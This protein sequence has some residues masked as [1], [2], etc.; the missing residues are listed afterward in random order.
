M[1]FVALGGSAVWS[2]ASGPR[3]TGDER[4][5]LQGLSIDRLP[6]LPPDPSNRVADNSRAVKLGQALFFDSRLSA[7]G[8]VSCASCHQPVR[9]FSDALPLGRGVGQTGRRTM[10]VVGV[11]YAPFLFWD[12]RKDSLWAQALGPLESAV[13]HGGDR[14]MYARLIARYHRARYEAL[15]GPLPDLTGLPQHA[16]PV[17]NLQARASWNGL[18]RSRQR[19]VTEVYVNI[20]KALAAYERRL[21][22]A[23]S[24]FDRYV[25]AVLANDTR[26]MRTTFT[27]AEADGLRLFIGRAS[28]VSCHSGPLLTDGDFHNTGIP[29]APGLPPDRGRASGAPLVRRDEFNCLSKYSDAPPSECV[30]LRFLKTDGPELEGQFKVPPLRGVARTAPYMHAGQKATLRD[31]LEHYNLA[32]SAAVGHSELMPLHLSGQ[33]L[34]HIEAFMRT[35]DSPVDAPAALLRDPFART[36]ATPTPQ[37]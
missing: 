31:V 17:Q 16:G 22:P 19:A 4:R 5:I 1:G 36:P 27:P 6:P 20:G 18:T 34:D 14:T 21:N 37:P 10:T 29:T 12:G 9:G 15:F 28:C 3:W 24:R 33:D 13:E 25:R 32:L 26:V 35:L 11:A 30:N 2:A 8:K 23:P 7:N